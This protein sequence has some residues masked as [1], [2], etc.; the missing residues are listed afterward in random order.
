MIKGTNKVISAIAQGYEYI[1]TPGK[2]LF[3][4]PKANLQEGTIPMT[5]QNLNNVIYSITKESLP[6]SKKETYHRAILD[7][8][9]R[10]ATPREI[11]VRVAY[12]DGAD[13]NTIFY[14]LGRAGIAK[15]T[16]KNIKIV[17][18]CPLPFLRSPT[19]QDLPMPV[20]DT[21]ISPRDELKSLWEL[22]NVE[23]KDRRLAVAWLLSAFQQEGTKVGLLLE[24]PQGSAKTSTLTTL[25]R[26]VDPHNPQTSSLQRQDKDLYIYARNRRIAAFD[27]V[28]DIKPDISDALCRILSGESMIIRKLYSDGDEYVVK[29]WSLIALN[30]IT[31]GAVRGDLLDRTI[32]LE[33][34][35]LVPG[36]RKTEKLLEALFTQRHPKILGAL[37]R[38]V[39]YGLQN[40]AEPPE[41]LDTGRLVDFAHW[42]YSWAPGL[43]LTP[44]KLV[45]RIYEN[46]QASKEEVLST[47][48]VSDF[49]HDLLRQEWDEWKGTATALYAKFGEWAEGRRFRQS[50]S[51]PKSAQAMSSWLMR[52]KPLLRAIGITCEKKPTKKN[53]LIILTKSP[54]G[55]K[56]SE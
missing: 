1:V 13:G 42:S 36:Q 28:S 14:D 47:D 38:T 34:N 56:T 44:E 45:T 4:R 12:D 55:E 30:G 25:A 46:Q 24:G 15:I 41:N 2:E 40:P 37:L 43:D 32:K 16:R 5:P 3:M 21:K 20:L 49:I 10:K 27:N 50:A 6:A 51:Y 8:A 19:M 39:Q 22:I 11:H 33:L 54:Q 18:H 52:T 23:S 17:D 53:R 31:T 29:A 9:K 48:D 26:I 7:E 35:E